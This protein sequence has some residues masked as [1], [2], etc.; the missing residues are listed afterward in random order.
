MN[1]ITELDNRPSTILVVDDD[2]T[3]MGVIVEY[4]KNSGF[5]VVISQDGESGLKRAAA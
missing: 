1:G 3:G 2:P 4:L 5:E